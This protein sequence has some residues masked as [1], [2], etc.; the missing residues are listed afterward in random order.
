MHMDSGDSI[1]QLRGAVEAGD[2]QM[3]ELDERQK[4]ATS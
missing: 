2:I 4:R 1:A 3:F